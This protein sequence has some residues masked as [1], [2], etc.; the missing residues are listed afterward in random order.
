MEI[1]CAS[2]PL[3]MIPMIVTEVQGAIAG[4]QSRPTDQLIDIRDRARPGTV[5]AVMEP[6][7]DGHADA[8]VPGSTCHR[9]R[10]DLTRPADLH[11]GQGL[12]RSIIDKSLTQRGGTRCQGTPARR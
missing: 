5:M 1:T 4:G 11:L 6:L 8:V 12:Q 10:P 7:F 3:V 2:K 9:F